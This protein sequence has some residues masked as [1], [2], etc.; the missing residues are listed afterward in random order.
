MGE[1]PFQD[2]FFLYRAAATNPETNS[3]NTFRL[4]QEVSPVAT[5]P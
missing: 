4:I 5:L 1:S 2:C 3:I